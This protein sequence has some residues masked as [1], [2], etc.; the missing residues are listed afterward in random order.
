M[1]YRI[2]VIFARTFVNFVSSALI[3]S[4]N[5]S[6]S[7]MNNIKNY[8]IHTEQRR[9]AWTAHFKQRINVPH[10]QSV[11]TSWKLPRMCRSASLRS[12]HSAPTSRVSSSICPRLSGWMFWPCNWVVSLSNEVNCCLNSPCLASANFELVCIDL[13]SIDTNT[14]IK[15]QNCTLYNN[16]NHLLYNVT[17]HNQSLAS[18]ARLAC[19]V[20]TARSSCER[21]VWRR[22]LSTAIGPAPNTNNP[23]QI[24]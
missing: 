19:N 8:L 2:A 12:S 14:V 11:T 7:P 22:F 15:P 23:I 10:T 9:N 16:W 5:A 18:Y 13:C 3:W 21:S 6:R 1:V 4:V 17:G 20:C 24:S